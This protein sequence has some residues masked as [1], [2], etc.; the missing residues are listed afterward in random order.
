[1]TIELS[2]AFWTCLQIV[3]PVLLFARPLLPREPRGLITLAATVLFAA[4]VL[5]LAVLVPLAIEVNE[6]LFTPVIFVCSLVLVWG[7]VLLLF[8][9]APAPALFCATAGYTL[10]NLVSGL[11]GMPNMLIS[12]YSELPFEV[13][14]N[15]I[16]PYVIVYG[17]SYPVLIRRVRRDGLELIQPQAMFGILL[18]VMLAVIVYDVVIKQLYGYDL[19]TWIQLAIRFSHTML[20]VLVL[21]LEYELLYG[22]R[23]RQE[24]AT[25]SQVM[26]AERAQY[27]MS[28]ETIAAINVKCHDIRR[29]I[30]QLG[31]SSGTV[32]PALLAEMEREVNVYDATVHT[33]L[34][35]LDVILTEKSLI[36]QREGIT[37]T[38]MADGAA[39]SFMAAA[40][41]Y[42][43]MGNALDNAIEAA[44]EVDDPARRSV[45]VLIRRSGDMASIHVENYFEGELRFRDGLPLAGPEGERGHGYGTR[46]M[47]LVAQRYDGTLH[48]RAEGGVFHLNAALPIPEPVP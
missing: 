29:Q 2:S 28:R 15:S 16:L 21:V 39:L 35:P 45:S 19:A 30:H 32:D 36:C 40:D 13:L 14:R 48:L 10:Q 11:A 17:L 4:W 27:Q 44:R 42:S 41:L 34:E 31:E 46:S 38:V 33:D 1:M 20:C 6:M 37:L 24:V 43:F 25:M 22:R 26:A 47:Q 9:T 18:V 3:V 23:L 12:G 5:L 8:Q 7:I